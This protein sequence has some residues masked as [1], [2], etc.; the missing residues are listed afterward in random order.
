MKRLE[1]RLLFLQISCSPDSVSPQDL[2]R[3]RNLRDSLYQHRFLDQTPF[4]L[5]GF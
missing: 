2:A 4:R 5:Q 3:Y 1:F